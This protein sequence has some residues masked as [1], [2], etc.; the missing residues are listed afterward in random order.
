MAVKGPDEISEH[1]AKEAFKGADVPA[2]M[3]ASS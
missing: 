3:C 1:C 2:K